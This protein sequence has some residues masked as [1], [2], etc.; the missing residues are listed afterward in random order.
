VTYYPKDNG[1]N[2]NTAT[3][4]GVIESNRTFLASEL[5]PR[6]NYTFE[7][8]AFNGDGYGPA[9]NATFQTSVPESIYIFCI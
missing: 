8:L 3:V 5:Q 7:V 2:K 9:A 6:T 1:S 4:Y